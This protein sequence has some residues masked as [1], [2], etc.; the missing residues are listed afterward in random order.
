[1]E[2]WFKLEK[3]QKKYFRIQ[4]A[5]RLAGRPLF[6]ACFVKCAIEIKDRTFEDFSKAC[7]HILQEMVLEKA[8]E[9]FGKDW[10]ELSDVG[11]SLYQLL[12][13]P[14]QF[15]AK[16]EGNLI[17][18]DK[19]VEPVFLQLQQMGILN[20]IKL[21]ACLFPEAF[22]IDAIRF[23]YLIITHHILINYYFF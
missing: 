7:D 21:S 6:T 20:F 9:R 17:K 13:K 8:M 2:A 14:S 4:V 5:P 12:R 10:N 11:V 16:I 1:M 23:F 19:G 22:I 18:F 15:K 3:E